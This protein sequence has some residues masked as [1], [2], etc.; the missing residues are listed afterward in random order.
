MTRDGTV[1]W[2]TGLSG[3]GKSTVGRLVRDGLAARGRP[4]LLLDGDVL[5]GVLGET[6]SHGRD[7][8]RRLAS[9]YSRLSREVASQGID[10]VCASISMFHSVRAWN[11]EHI[12]RY[13]EIYL[14]VPLPE[15]EARDPSGLYAR[16]RAG[17]P[18]MVVGLD[19][20]FEEPM[21]P[22]LVIDHVGIDPVEAAAR[23]LAL[24]PA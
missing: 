15:L 19:E 3:S 22:D 24:A 13:L 21:R 11:R 18:M 1:W 14:R 2:I 7:D 9:I 12:T 6:A 20:A 4:A 8:R 17:E 5:R 10:A 23:I 16:A